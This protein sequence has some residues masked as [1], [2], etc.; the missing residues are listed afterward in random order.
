[1]RHP[2]HG[3]LLDKELRAEVK[4]VTGNRLDGM[5]C[6]FSQGVVAHEVQLFM[7]DAKLL[8]P[9][10][11]WEDLH[12]MCDSSWKFPGHGCTSKNTIKNLFTELKIT[13]EGKCRLWASEALACAPVL[14]FFAESV[15]AQHPEGRM[16][17]LQISSLVHMCSA[18]KAWVDF[19]KSRVISKEEY[20]AKL[21]KYMD[22]RERAYSQTPPKP[23]L[24][25]L[26][27]MDGEVDCFPLERR[28]KGGINQGTQ[29]TSQDPLAWSRHVLSRSM[30][31]QAAR[32]KDFPTE[33]SYLESPAVHCAELTALIG[34]ATEVSEQAV[35][36]Y[37]AVKKGDVVQARDGAVV[38]VN[39]ACRFLGS[40]YI[41]GKPTQ[42]LRQITSGAS[43]R[44]V[45]GGVLIVD[46]KDA[47]G[48]CTWQDKGDGRIMVLGD[49][50]G[51]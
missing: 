6:W 30:L 22:S 32:F 41:I 9:P 45:M 35:L 12:N 8:R 37:L 11:T 1:M 13:E 51:S 3:P 10:I 29:M 16:M 23:K 43:E 49:P 15:V 38:L 47:I 4:P 19:S 27:H 25:Y 5:H 14:R 42:H 33:Q 31:Q 44:Q 17:Q 50:C 21:A 40:V 48:L 34:H 7:A 20:L 24:H 18:C 26:A 2:P 28:H 39:L 36:E 46:G